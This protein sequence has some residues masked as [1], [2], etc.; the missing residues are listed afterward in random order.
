MPLIFTSADASYMM[1]ILDREKKNESGALTHESDDVGVE[2]D[3]AHVLPPPPDPSEM[4]LFYQNRHRRFG[5]FR[6]FR[7]GD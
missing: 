7:Q 4:V 1:R 5:E 2:L 6:F 3:D